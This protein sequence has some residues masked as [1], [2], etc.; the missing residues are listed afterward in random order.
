MWECLVTA[1]VRLRR[2]EAA[3][4]R[5]T[6]GDAVDVDIRHGSRGREPAFVERHGIKILDP[7]SMTR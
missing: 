1:P 5:S 7:R 4:L 3:Q 6:A 2:D